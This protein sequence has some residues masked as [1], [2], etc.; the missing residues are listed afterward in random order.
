LKKGA[1]LTAGDL[2]FKR[3]GNGIGPDELTFAVGRLLARDVEA[4][5]ELEWSD[6][7]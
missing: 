3:P 7:A 4:E 2:D 6:L 5:E 1:R